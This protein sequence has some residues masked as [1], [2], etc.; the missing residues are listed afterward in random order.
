MACLWADPQVVPTRNDAKRVDFLSLDGCCCIRLGVCES[1]GQWRDFNFFWR[2]LTMFLGEFGEFSYIH[3]M[4][5]LDSSRSFQIEDLT[6]LVG[7]F[8]SL[9]RDF[10]S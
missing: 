2:K 6:R 7:N 4:E 10:G 1:A 3:G 5:H 8:R 9:V